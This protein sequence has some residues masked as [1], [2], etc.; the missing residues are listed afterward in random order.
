MSELWAE[1][2]VRD[3]RK[4]F[5]SVYRLNER[6]LDE[7]IVSSM[8]TH[9]KRLARETGIEES[10]WLV[11]VLHEYGTIGEPYGDIAPYT[12]SYDQW[13]K[14]VQKVADTWRSRRCIGR[15]GTPR[16]PTSSSPRCSSPDRHL[17]EPRLR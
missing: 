16:S 5:K 2:T 3:V 17:D 12:E 9:G 4:A 11:F 7:A 14:A 6:E 8:S 15:T 1:G 13:N 10:P